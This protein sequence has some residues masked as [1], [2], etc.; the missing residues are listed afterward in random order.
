MS[1]EQ[2]ATR[3]HLFSGLGRV[4]LC[5]HPYRPEK[6]KKKTKK[7][8]KT[9]KKTLLLKKKKV[10]FP[11]IY[12]LIVIAVLKKTKKPKKN[13]DAKCSRCSNYGG[14]SWPNH[15]SCC[16]WEYFWILILLNNPIFI[17]ITPT[18]FCK[19]SF[20]LVSKSFSF[21]HRWMLDFVTLFYD[22][23]GCPAI[24]AYCICSR[25]ISWQPNLS[26]FSLLF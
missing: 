1:R 2:V 3:I 21:L 17:G 4:W 6:V 15:K 8:L 23:T 9:L 16:R 18:Y 20:I 7:I 26:K 5:D 22:C 13:Q 11:L 19:K 24:V 10:A 14:Q 25:I 12:S